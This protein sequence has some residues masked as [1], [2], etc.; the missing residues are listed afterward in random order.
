MSAIFGKRRAERF[1]P[2]YLVRLEDKARREAEAKYPTL[3]DNIPFDKLRNYDWEGVMR[4]NMKENERLREEYVRKLL[5]KYEI[6]KS[7]LQAIGEEAN[8][9]QWPLP[10]F[11]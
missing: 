5:R 9:E 6:S 11:R 7:E 1:S 3:G 8:M 2:R 4:K 10:P